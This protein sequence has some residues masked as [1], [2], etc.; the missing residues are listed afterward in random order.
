MRKQ[1]LHRRAFTLIELLL[2]LVILGVLAA[3]VVPRFANRGDDAKKT[4]AR[5]E[6]GTIGAA[7][8][9]YEIDNGSYPTSE[10]GIVALMEAPS[11]A[12][13]WKGPYLKKLPQD[14]WGNQYIYQR[15]GQHN[16]DYDLYSMGPDGREGTDD[17]DSWSKN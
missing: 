14:P 2:V 11:S 17:I 16:Q 8:D 12:K 6:I 15:P 3:V 4:A 1:S 7:L 10:E 5:A 13:N 9:R